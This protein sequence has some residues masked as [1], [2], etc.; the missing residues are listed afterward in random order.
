MAKAKQ[1]RGNRGNEGSAILAKGVESLFHVG[2]VWILWTP[3]LELTGLG[4]EVFG[5][6]EFTVDLNQVG[7]KYG[8]LRLTPEGLAPG[9]LRPT[10]TVFDGA[11]GVVPC[12]KCSVYPTQ[13]Y[14]K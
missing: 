3:G 10:I 9:Y 12:S 14:T 13:N 7:A 6:V 4:D 2:V 1:I 5:K 8:Y 11:G